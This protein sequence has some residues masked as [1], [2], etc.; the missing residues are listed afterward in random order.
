LANF[1]LIVAGW[2]TRFV[3][4]TLAK[5]NEVLGLQVRKQPW[6]LAADTCTSTTGFDVFVMQRLQQRPQLFVYVVV[7]AH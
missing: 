1:G 4:Y 5:D 3:S 2:F 6:L 7:T